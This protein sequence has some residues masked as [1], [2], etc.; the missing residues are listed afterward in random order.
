[1]RSHIRWF[2][3]LAGLVVAPTSAFAQGSNLGEVPPVDFTAFLSHPR[4]EDGGIFAGVDF[5]YLNTNRPLGSQVVAIRGFLDLDG[6]ITGTPGTFNGSGN[7]ALNTNQVAG[8]GLYEPGFNVFLGWRFQGGVTVE[9][10]WL[11]MTPAVYQA[12][13]S[14]LPP[15]YQAGKLLQNTFLT[16]FVTNFT[17]DWAGNDINVNGGD[18]GSTFGIW[19]AASFMQITYTQSFDM[20]QL[21]VRIPIWDTDNYRNY[22]MIGPRF[23]QIQDKFAWLTIDADNT[24]AFTS[25]TEATYTNTITNNMYGIHAGFGNEWFLG[26]TPLGAWSFSLDVEGS[27]YANLVKAEFNWDRGDGLVSQGRTRNLTSI[28]PG[29]EA[30][31]GLTWYPWEAV[32]IHIGYDIMMFFNTLGSTQPID[33]N[34]G[35]MNPQVNNIFF[36]YIH[37]GNIGINFVF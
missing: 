20:Y 7:P 31:L 10:S 13:A 30:R 4:Y 25:D 11:H 15:S 29:L 33:F 6:S 19:N 21:N 18:V 36:R 1:M 32:S 3:F 5:N 2:L 9:A 23:V 12:S 16:A 8:S 24:G 22:G 17:N 35:T 37:G 14:L 26:S 34:M 28:V 27:L